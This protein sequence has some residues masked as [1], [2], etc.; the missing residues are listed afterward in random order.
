[1]FI[2]TVTTRGIPVYETESGPTIGYDNI[3]TY[4]EV[5]H[6]REQLDQALESH[7]E[8]PEGVASVTVTEVSSIIVL[9]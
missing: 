3:S 1:M 7:A 5:V 4:A 9:G 2:I 6:T 8:D